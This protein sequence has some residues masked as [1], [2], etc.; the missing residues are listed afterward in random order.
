MTTREQQDVRYTLTDKGLAATERV[1][2]S[3]FTRPG[4]EPYWPNPRPTH[5]SPAGQLHTGHADDCTDCKPQ[6]NR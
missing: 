2:S 6:E 4:V 5:W 1:V 3:D